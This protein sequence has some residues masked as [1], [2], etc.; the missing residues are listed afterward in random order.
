MRHEKRQRMRQRPDKFMMVGVRRSL[1]C[2]AVLLCAQPVLAKEAVRRP[3][4]Q[5]APEGARLPSRADCPDPVAAPGRKRSGVHR[6][7]DVEIRVGGQVTLD[8]DMRR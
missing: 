7:G 2:C 1:V 8:Y 5:D 4:L 6:I 3:C